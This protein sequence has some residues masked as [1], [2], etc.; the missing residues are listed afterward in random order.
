[1]PIKQSSGKYT[2]V[3]RLTKYNYNNNKHIQPDVSLHLF[4]Y[5]LAENVIC[6]GYLSI[7]FYHK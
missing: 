5:T 7:L 4:Y 3:H 1:M 6:L 2:H